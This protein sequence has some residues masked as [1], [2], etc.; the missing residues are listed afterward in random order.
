M[1]KILIGDILK[2]KAQ[3]LI[4]TVNCVGIMGKGIALEFKKRFPEMYEDYVGRCDRKEVKVGVPYLFKTL[5]PPQIVNF[6]TKTHWRAASRIADIEKG[7]DYMVGHYQEWGVAS[8]AVPPLGCGSGQ[9]E[10]E[11]VGPLLYSRMKKLDMP[12]EIY[13]PYGTSPQQLTERFLEQ[14]AER[15]SA[16]NGKQ[17]VTK[18]NPAWVA[19][20][21]ILRRI[22][23]HSYHPLIGRIIFQKIAYVATEQGLPT[24]LHYSR[25]SFGPFAKELKKITAK[26][27]NSNLLREKRIGQ[28]FVITT[29][30]NYINIRKLYKD[31]LTQWEPIV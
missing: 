12:L 3:T 19:L 25:G 18:L 4:N 31:Q 21:E 20:I 2:S 15:T 22:E 17:V 11:E 6:P 7:L 24:E 16:P 9:L 13:A 1:M 29:V 23:E 30:S 10:W 5:I 28:M 27:S 14:D 26:L 8:L